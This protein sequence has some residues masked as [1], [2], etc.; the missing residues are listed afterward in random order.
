MSRIVWNDTGARRFEFG[1]DRGVVYPVVG[2]GQSHGAVPWN[3]LVSVEE[4]HTESDVQRHYLDGVKFMNELQPEDFD[5]TIEAYT[6][7]DEIVRYEGGS[8]LSAGSSGLNV[9][10]GLTFYQQD[11]PEFNLVYRTKIGNDTQG[12]NAGY[13]LHIVYNITLLPSSRARATMEDETEPT[14]FSWEFVTRPEFVDL[15]PRVGVTLPLS[16]LTV[17]ST[18]TNPQNLQH[19]ENTLYGTESSAGSLPDISNLIGILSDS[20]PFYGYGLGQYG[21]GMYGGNVWSP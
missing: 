21:R 9:P 14:L 11:R 6:Y 3:G 8:T 1:V 10:N 19:L 15:S 7:P 4:N 2:W 13:K 16:Y 17:D 18:K 20:P 5:G 12:Q